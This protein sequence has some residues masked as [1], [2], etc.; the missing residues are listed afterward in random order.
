MFNKFCVFYL[1][2]KTQNSMTEHIQNL[3][4]IYVPDNK[5]T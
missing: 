3:M 5:K 2:K 4:K 1:T